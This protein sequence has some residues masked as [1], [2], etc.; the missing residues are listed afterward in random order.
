MEYVVARFGIAGIAIHRLVEGGGVG[1]RLVGIKRAEQLLG[2]VQPGP[3]GRKRSI[4]WRAED[5]RPVC[6]SPFIRGLC[7]LGAEKHGAGQVQGVE[8]VRQRRQ[9]KSLNHNV[10]HRPPGG[11]M[12][13]ELRDRLYLNARH[14][15]QARSRCVP[16][17]RSCVNAAHARAIYARMGSPEPS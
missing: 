1:R 6:A 10:C 13:F 5:H 8:R 17:Q 16:E 3:V 4:K 12:G 2:R 9:V 15:G 7:E 11:K 14:S